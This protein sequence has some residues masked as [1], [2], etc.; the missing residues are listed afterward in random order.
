MP[1]DCRKT[2][3]KFKIFRGSMPMDPPRHSEPRARD[4]PSARFTNLPPLINTFLRLCLLWHITYT[5]YILHFVACYTHIVLCDT[6]WVATIFLFRALASPSPARLIPISNL[7][8]RILDRRQIFAFPT[9]ECSLYDHDLHLR[10]EIFP[11]CTQFEKL[12][13][14]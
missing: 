14:S 8:T 12:G 4:V 5:F 9:A 11:A 6:S 2:H 10:T 3:L 1:P 7:T 13:V